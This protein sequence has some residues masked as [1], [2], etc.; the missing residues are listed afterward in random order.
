M[1]STTSAPQEDQKTAPKAGGGGFYASGKAAPASAKK[2]EDD[3]MIDTRS[4]KPKTDQPEDEDASKKT[5]KCNHGP[6][7][8]CINCMTYKFVPNAAPAEDA[9]DGEEKKD[10]PKNKCSHGPN[11]KCLNCADNGFI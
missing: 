2:A 11:G 1:T 4:E 7:G 9:K 5:G 8:K 10:F 3:M 6:K